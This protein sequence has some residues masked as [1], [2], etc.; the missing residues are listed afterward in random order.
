MLAITCHAAQPLLFELSSTFM[1]S[2]H[3]TGP[4]PPRPHYPGRCGTHHTVSMTTVRHLWQFSVL[5]GCFE[6]ASP[7]CARRLPCRCCRAL[8]MLMCSAAAVAHAAT[9]NST[10]NEAAARLCCAMAPQ[11][12]AANPRLAPSTAPFYC[13]RRYRLTRDA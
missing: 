13:W 10:H 9:T 6:T 2:E 12:D 3:N 5:A 8:S 11:L 7:S 1:A 4:P